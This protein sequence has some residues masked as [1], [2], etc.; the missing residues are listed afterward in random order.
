MDCQHLDELHELWLLGALTNEA[1]RNLGEH[2]AHGCL[3]CLPRVRDAAGMIYL[4]A[5]DA[6]PLR[7]H[8]RTKTSLL[9]KISPPATLHG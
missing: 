6:K 1:S 8:P 9:S 5:L 4:L 2:L 3:H 7:P